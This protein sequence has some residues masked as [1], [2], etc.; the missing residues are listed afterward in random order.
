MGESWIKFV[1]RI[2]DEMNLKTLGEAMKEARI[3]KSE[4]KKEGKHDEGHKE[5]KDKHT[6]KRRS[7][8]HH[9]GGK[10]SRKNHKK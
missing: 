8:R 7:R 10:K 6:R 9:K 4:W 3:R 2:K 1:M 5:H